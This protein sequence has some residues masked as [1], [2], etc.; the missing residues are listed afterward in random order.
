MHALIPLLLLSLPAAAEPATPDPYAPLAYLAGHCYSGSMKGG[1]DIDTH[2]FSWVYGKHFVRDVHVVKGEGHDDYVGETIYYW[3]S[4]DRK[5]KYLYVENKGGSSA[6]VVEIADPALVF[7]P[8]DF[9]AGGKTQTYRSRWTRRGDEGYD[10]VTE[11][12]QADGSW[13]GGWVVRFEKQTAR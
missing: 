7:P 10:A 11:F 4:T 8:T 1:K 6:G 3:D 12:K 5:L 2:C 13:G 9:Q